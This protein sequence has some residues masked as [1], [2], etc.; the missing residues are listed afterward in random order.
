ML[1]SAVLTL[2][3][4]APA[5]VPAYLGRATHAWFLDQVRSLD[6]A[7]A[8]CLHAPN[9][10]RPFT[11]SNLWGRRGRELPTF[12]KVGNSLP[13]M[14]LAPDRP[15]FLRLTSYEP[16]L[17]ALLTDRLLPN[18]PETIAL[19]GATLRMLN[20]TTDPAQHPWA[21]QTTTQDLLLAHTL[22]GQPPPRLT[23]RFA[24]PT[25]FHSNKMYL[26][27][28]LPRLVVEGLV[29]RWNATAPV[30]LPVE[31]N[32]FADECMAISRYHLRTERIA[33][34]EDN[35]HGPAS[36]FVGAVSYSFLN[37]DRYWMGLIHLLA[38]FALYAGVGMGTTTGLGQVRKA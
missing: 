6:P 38:A 1:I 9:Q 18:L 16:A 2:Q 10:E 37:K 25:A 3:P 14:A 33:F 17:S 29:R 19:A 26:P 20:A 31:V 13:P 4:T 7:L 8:D 5:T 27:L 12:Q 23:L 24:S 21:G 35:E 32:R 11:V 15:C 34:G 22:H 28:P 36:G 30:A